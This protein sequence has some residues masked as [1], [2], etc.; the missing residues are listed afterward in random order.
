MGNLRERISKY[1]VTAFPCGK[2]QKI[3]EKHIFMYVNEEP[4]AR[5][6]EKKKVQKM[7]IKTKYTHKQRR[8]RQDVRI[9]KRGAFRGSLHVKSS[10]FDDQ[11]TDV[12]T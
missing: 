8:N 11:T 9:Y 6:T 7:L 3:K 12:A 4:V 2:K 5:K 10:D 1:N